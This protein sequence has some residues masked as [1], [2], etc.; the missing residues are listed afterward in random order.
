MRMRGAKR[1]GIAPVM[2]GGSEMGEQV[3]ASPESAAPT[4][5]RTNWNK[6]DRFR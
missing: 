1:Y 3:T 2:V 4:D 5:T 6:F